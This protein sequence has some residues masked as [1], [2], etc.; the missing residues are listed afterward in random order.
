MFCSRCHVS[1]LQN[2]LILWDPGYTCKP[3]HVTR[4]TKHLSLQNLIEDTV[5]RCLKLAFKSKFGST[6]HVGVSTACQGEYFRFSIAK[7]FDKTLQ[8]NPNVTPF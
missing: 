8:C 1:E 3:E 5:A 4:R 7:V 6:S 2:L